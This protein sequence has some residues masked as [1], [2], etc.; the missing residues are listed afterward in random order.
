MRRREVIAALSAAAIGSPFA[1]RAEP[2]GGLRQ[3]GALMS[4]V[5]TELEMPDRVAMLMKGLE[6]EGWRE[7]SVKVHWRWLGSGRDLAGSSVDELVRMQP[8]VLVVSSTAL[9]TEVLRRTTSIPVVFALVADP[10]ASGFV[11][12]LARPAG[13]AT[14]FLN[15]E[16]SLAGK[17]AQLLKEV[18]PNLAH[19]VIMYSPQATPL[20]GD[21]YY[22]PFEA[23]AFAADV[24]P[25]RAP[26]DRK[27]EI[28]GAA[29]AVA[30][31]ARSGLVVAP[32]LFTSTHR[33]EIIAAATRLRLP[34]I[35]GFRYRAVDG[36]LMSYGIDTPDVFR[37]VG[38]YVG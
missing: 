11:E 13:N 25:S 38:K 35:F 33:R 12:S 2:T 28:D 30:V 16:A 4:I 6:E 27:E 26:V 36:G 34:T 15:F 17:W 8:D 10:I 24:R 1:G 18:V 20:G 29:A 37:L 19:V 31:V 5:E 22:P 32:D 3:I 23:A 21:Y 14:G 9:T 7:G